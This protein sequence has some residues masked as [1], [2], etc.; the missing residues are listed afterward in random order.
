MNREKLEGLVAELERIYGIRILLLSECSSRAW[1]LS[2]KSSDHDMAF[3]YHQ[4]PWMKRLEDQ[5]NNIHHTKFEGVD[6]RG[7]DI[8]R[9]FA[10]AC[11]SNLGMYEMIYSPLRYAADFCASSLMRNTVDKY[12]AP[13]V[14]FDSLKGHTKKLLL[15]HEEAGGLQTITSKDF[16][17]ML[18]FSCMAQQIYGGT[19]LKTDMASVKPA[20]YTTEE[21]DVLTNLRALV[22]SD[23]N[24][25]KESYLF[26]K[27]V[28]FCQ[29]TINLQM[30][31]RPPRKI[32]EVFYEH[33]N[34]NHHALQKWCGEDRIKLEYFKEA[35]Q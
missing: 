32:D 27:V 30:V 29:H 24:L 23:F 12:Y 9:S 17:Y 25:F 5:S 4:L 10:L 8:R 7:Y 6:F 3:I 15:K 28:A 11:N 35:F 1:G 13:G 18:R 21:Y 33:A 31:E 22:A 14:L 20:D 16:Q 26:K 2:T 19:K 34:A